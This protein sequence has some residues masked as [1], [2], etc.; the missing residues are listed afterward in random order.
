MV[1]EARDPESHNGTDKSFCYEILILIS[2]VVFVFLL[3]TRRDAVTVGFFQ[4]FPLHKEALSLR[5][6]F[7][8]VHQG[9]IWIVMIVVRPMG[10]FP[11]HWR[12]TSLSNWS[13]SM[14]SDVTDAC[15]ISS[16]THSFVD[17]D[18][19]Q[20]GQSSPAVSVHWV[21]AALYPPKSLR[22]IKFR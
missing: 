8:L 18:F 9:L 22:I 19:D 7:A 13:L 1:R 2:L 12:S 6:P 5:L 4:N 17:T 21:L 3:L 16:A 15:P 14:L 10:L 20:I 11:L